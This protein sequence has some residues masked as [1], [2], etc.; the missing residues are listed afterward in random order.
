MYNSILF[1][2]QAHNRANLLQKKYFTLMQVLEIMVMMNT[3]A[4]TTITTM[5]MK[6]ILKMEGGITTIRMERIIVSYKE[7]SEF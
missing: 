6:P 3:I 2:I 7:R 4:E 1:F 5:V